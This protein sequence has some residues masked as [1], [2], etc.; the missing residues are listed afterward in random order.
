MTRGAAMNAG[1]LAARLGLAGWP[2]AAEEVILERDVRLVRGTGCS[3]H[4]QHLS[5]GGAVEILRRA[6]ADGLPV[7]REAIPHHRLLTEDA[8]RAYD[9][10]AK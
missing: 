5:C 1:I 7:T 3:Y 10:N 6:R 9:T 2:A 4:A 8:C